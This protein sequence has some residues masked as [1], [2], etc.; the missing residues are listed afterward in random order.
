MRTLRWIAAGGLL[1]LIA[2]GVFAHWFDLLP[3]SEIEDGDYPMRPVR[4]MAECER[5]DLG[6]VPLGQPVWWNAAPD[7]YVVWVASNTNWRTIPDTKVRLYPKLKSNRALYGAIEFGRYEVKSGKGR[8]FRC[9]VD[10][11]AGSGT[12]YDRLYFDANADLD[13]TNDPVLT[14]IEPQSGLTARTGRQGRST[15]FHP[16]AIPFDF[17]PK[18]GEKP[19][20]ITPRLIESDGMEKCEITLQLFM[21][22]ARKGMIRIGR[23]RCDALMCQLQGITGRFDNPATALHL[24]EAGFFQ[25]QTSWEWWG[26]EELSSIRLVDGKLYTIDTTPT[27]DLLM[28]RRYRGELGTLRIEPGKRN[29]TN[30][31]MSGW[32]ASETATVPVGRRPQVSG[33]LEMVRECELPVGDYSPNKMSFRYGRLAFWISQNYHID[34][35]R[36]GAKSGNRWSCSIKIRKDRPFLLDFSNHPEIMFLSPA[37]DQIFKAGEEVVVETVLTDPAMGTMV[38]DMDDTSRKEKRKN[39][40]GVVEVNLSLAPTVKILDSAGNTIAEGTMPFG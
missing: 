38:R 14:P 10:E 13:L 39:G 12:G 22:E 30:V 20:E 25:H 7:K 9:V 23:H 32:L 21:S 11:S 2:A 37:K 27:G 26:G 6:G 36:N 8:P 40:D 31:K 29:I 19:V 17:G 5:L 18:Y 1:A 3:L 16:L 28:V 34:G 33:Y 4:A 24:T 35:K 15:T